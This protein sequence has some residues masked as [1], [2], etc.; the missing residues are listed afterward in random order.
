MSAR[1]SK[2]QFTEAQPLWIDTLWEEIEQ[3]GPDDFIQPNTNIDPTKDIVAGPASLKA[4][5]LYSL[6]LQYEKKS[7][8]R[9]IESRYEQDNRQKQVLVSLSAEYQAKCDA[10]LKLFWITVD[11]EYR[12]W[13]KR[14]TGIR[15]NWTVVYSE[16][17]DE[18]EKPSFEDFLRGMFGSR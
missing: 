5:K 12:L 8:E 11:E 1:K 15:T 10:L 3:I 14:S 7:S 18:P 16:H 9:G 6:A 4:R 17:T 2:D 13:G